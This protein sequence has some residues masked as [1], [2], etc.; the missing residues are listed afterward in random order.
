[1]EKCQ[2]SPAVAATPTRNTTVPAANKKP[3]NRTSKRIS[4]YPFQPLRRNS[5]RFLSLNAAAERFAQFAQAP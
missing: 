4:E 5:R 3:M 1:L 2:I